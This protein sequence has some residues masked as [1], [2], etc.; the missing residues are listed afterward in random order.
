MPLATILFFWIGGV[1]ITI[2]G[3]GTMYHG[4]GFYG[5]TLASWPD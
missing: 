3:L 2:K 1:D 5:A 4:Y